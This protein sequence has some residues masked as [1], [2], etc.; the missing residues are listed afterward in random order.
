LEATFE[1]DEDAYDFYRALLPDFKDIDISLEGRKVV[2]YLPGLTPSKARA[3]ANS[4]LRIIQLYQRISE[5]T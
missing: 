4:L 1:R 5:L 2:V 3:L